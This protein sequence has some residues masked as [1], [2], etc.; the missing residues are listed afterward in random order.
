MNEDNTMSLLTEAN[1]VRAEDLAELP[2]PDARLVRDRTGRRLRAVAAIASVAIAASLIGVFALGGSGSKATQPRGAIEGL[3]GPTVNTPLITGKKVTLQQAAGVLGA[4]LVLPDT[5]LVGP[6]DVGPVWAVSGGPTMGTAAVTYPAQRLI[7]YYVRPSAQ[8]DP[9]A[10][11]RAIAKELSGAQEIELDGTPALA[12]PQ[13]SDDTGANFGVVAFT[14]DGIEIRVMGHNDEATLETIARSILERE[15]AP[16]GTPGVIAPVQEPVS[17]TDLSSTMGRPVVLPRT[18]LAQPS[19]AGSAWSEGD[20]VHGSFCDVR[21]WFPIA[22]LS[23]SYTRPTG[24]PDS[25]A[26]FEDVAHNVRF[27]DG[28]VID[29]NGVSAIVIENQDAAGL[30]SIAFLWKGTRIEVDAYENAGVL[31]DLAQS[32]LDQLRGTSFG[33]FTASPGVDLFPIVPPQEKVNV[34]DASATLGAPIVLPDTV[35]V[36]PS[37]AASAWAEGQCPHATASSADGFSGCAVWIK[38]PAKSLTIVY[39]RP[40]GSG[41][42]VPP[43]Q[44]KQ[45]SGAHLVDVGGLPALAI[46]RNAEG[47]NPGWVEFAIHGTRVI[48]SG[49]YDTATLQSIGQSIVDRSK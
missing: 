26:G 25:R 16:P 27:G 23:V 12:I 2:M 8:S 15:S 38:F 14:V 11:Y 32:M 48:I 13:N 42:G 10:G 21:I 28:E 22:G 35:K 37:D 3:P 17:L 30:G 39:E 36:R 34:S 6:A 29:L 40:G 33:P 19:D 41:A 44:V 18:S 4:S 46:D 1:P 7:V 9:A 43:E 49:D 24:M 31:S 20:C 45:M 5:P 47:A